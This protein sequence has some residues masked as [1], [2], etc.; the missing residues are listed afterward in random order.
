MIGIGT[1]IYLITGGVY[2]FM[3][4]HLFSKAWPEEAPTTLKWLLVA[5]MI[6]HLSRVVLT[7]PFYLAEDLLIF[8]TAFA[9]V[10]NPEGPDV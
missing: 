3:E 7:W 8:M 6:I 5:Q 1:A 2:A 9:E 4:N 10:N